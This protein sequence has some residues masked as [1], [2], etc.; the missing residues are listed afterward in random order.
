[1]D[2]TITVQSE[3]GGGST[4]VVRLPTQAAEPP[5]PLASSLHPLAASRRRIRMVYADTRVERLY[6]ELWKQFGYE[7]LAASPQTTA[8]D[9]CR[10]TDVLWVDA[11]SLRASA[12]LTRLLTNMSAE[13]HSENGAIVLPILCIVY[14]VA[15]EL[16]AL[17][18]G[19]KADRVYLVRQPV[20]MHA[21]LAFLDA[22]CSLV[23]SKTEVP[24]DD[25]HSPMSPSRLI[26]RTPQPECQSQPRKPKVLLVEDNLVSYV[27]SATAP[28]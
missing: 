21:V 8:E 22:S 14:S 18:P 24:L 1:M 11:T 19:I 27:S 17:G 5:T 23:K 12:G 6:I 16:I 26:Q 13:R 7:A 9:L 20:V 10:G 15:E 25:A 3:L 4:F 2:G 28:A